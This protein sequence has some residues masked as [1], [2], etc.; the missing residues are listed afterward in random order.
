M[1][2]YNGHIRAKTL[3]DYLNNTGISV[4]EIASHL[5]ISRVMVGY[6][7]KGKKWNGKNVDT[8]IKYIEDRINESGDYK[9]LV[10]KLRSL[11]DSELSRITEL[12]NK[13]I[14]ERETEFR[15]LV[16][17]CAPGEPAGEKSKLKK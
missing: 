14:E 16:P 4:K 13:I 5:D 8:A 15:E 11:K 10:E 7:R 12:A 3:D 17:A 1:A 6:Y 2:D 9:L